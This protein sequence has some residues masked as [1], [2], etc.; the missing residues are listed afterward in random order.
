MSSV[1]SWRGKLNSGVTR[2]L[3]KVLTV[4]SAVSAK[5]WRENWLTKVSTGPPSRG[6]SRFTRAH[7]AEL[8][9]AMAAV[10][11][12]SSSSG[13]RDP[14]SSTSEAARRVTQA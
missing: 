4:T 12:T 9:T 5:N 2:W 7:S 1:K 3:N 8:A 11:H 14:F 6:A 10:L 13:R